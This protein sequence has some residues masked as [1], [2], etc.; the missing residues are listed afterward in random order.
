MKALDGKQPPLP[1]IGD[2]GY[3]VE[4]LFEVGLV[5]SNGMGVDALGFPEIAAWVYMCRHTLTPWEVLTLRS[6][7]AAYASE[8]RTANSPAAPPPWIELPS[9]EQRIQIAKNVRGW[10]HG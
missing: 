8:S 7:S 6:M 2:F 5:S 4:Y 3:M 1:S 9:E 10:L